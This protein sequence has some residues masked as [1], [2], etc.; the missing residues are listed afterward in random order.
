MII[1]FKTKCKNE[2]QIWAVAKK[3]ALEENGFKI[4]KT[5]PPKLL[6]NNKVAI[7]GFIQQDNN[8][9]KLRKIPR[10]TD[11]FMDEPPVQPE[12]FQF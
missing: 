1:V 8:L 2:I 6:P 9:K 10:V 7:R 12:P 4:D 5:Y 11:F 3:L